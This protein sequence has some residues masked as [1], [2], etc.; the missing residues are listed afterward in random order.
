MSESKSRLAEAQE[1]GSVEPGTALLSLSGLGLRYPGTPPVAAL[2]AVD[3]EVLRNEYLAIMGPSGSGKS[4]LLSV[5]GLLVAYTSGSYQV[6]GQDSSR[7]S[8]TELTALRANAIGF[9]FQDFLLIKSR[10]A[11]ENVALSGLYRGVH[12]RDRLSEARDMLRRVGLGHRI[13]ATPATLSGGERQ[14]VAIARAL[15]GHP[16]L[17][18]CDE[19]T[20][21]LDS[22]STAQVLDLLDELHR[23]G[24]TIVVVTHEPDV[25]TRADRCV[26][27]L[28]GRLR[29]DMSGSRTGQ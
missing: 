2:E 6:D 9:V 25:A 11:L 26:H 10:T 3:L 4:S 23:E 5:L 29:T 14:R 8:A 7:L 16:A 21:S 17:L 19:P 18:L 1:G 22:A 13:D 24:Q 28:D 15:V 20:G 12:R 27:M